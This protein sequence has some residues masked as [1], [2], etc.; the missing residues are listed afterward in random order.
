MLVELD[1]PLHHHEVLQV[2]AHA[3]HMQ[4]WMWMLTH[5]VLGFAPEHLVFMFAIFRNVRDNFT[6]AL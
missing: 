2:P 5:K 3:G 4:M 1:S 6:L